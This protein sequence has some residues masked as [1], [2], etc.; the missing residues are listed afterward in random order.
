MESVTIANQE[1]MLRYLDLNV[2]ISWSAT[3]WTYLATS[4]KVHTI[5]VVDACGNLDLNLAP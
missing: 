2:E 3:A 5:A 4:G 1:I